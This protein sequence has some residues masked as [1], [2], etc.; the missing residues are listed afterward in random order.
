MW[1]PELA[2]GLLFQKYSGDVTPPSSC[3]YRVNLLSRVCQVRLDF[4]DLQTKLNSLGA[5]DPRNY[6]RIS[7]GPDQLAKVPILQLC[8]NISEGGQMPSLSTDLP[9]LYVHFDQLEREKFGWIQPAHVKLDLL[10]DSHPSSWNIRV[11]QITCGNSRLQAPTG[12]S[13][14]YT[15]IQ[16]TMTSFGLSDGQYQ[17]VLLAKTQLCTCSLS[18]HS[19]IKTSL[20][21]SPLTQAPVGSSTI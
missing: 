5:C 12:C 15:S 16:G 10:T 18:I 7:A 17:V 14:Y 9:H 21:V 13:Q 8:G 3:S 1:L 4:V 11:T 19:R 20:L 6:L 2:K